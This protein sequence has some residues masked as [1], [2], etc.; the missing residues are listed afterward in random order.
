MRAALFALALA[1]CAT[2][3]PSAENFARLNGCWGHSTSNQTERM[4]W[5]ENAGAFEGALETATGGT[6]GV[7]RQSSFT[8]SQSEAGWRLCEAS[9]EGAPCWL[10]A[11]E[12][13]GS[14]EGGRAFIDRFGDRLRIGVIA[15]DGAERKIFE[16][17]RQA[18]PL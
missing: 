8:L 13:T 7:V 17:E 10:V 15:A 11:H 3:P 9:A 12:S 6:S 14:L 1:A 2:S 16:G 4:T 18:C 5:R